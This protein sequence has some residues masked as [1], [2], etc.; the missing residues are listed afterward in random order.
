MAEKITR[1]SF[2]TYMESVLSEY[3]K[4]GVKYVPTITKNEH[5]TVIIELRE[6]EQDG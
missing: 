3:I 5:G 1:I 6:V 4:P 2:P